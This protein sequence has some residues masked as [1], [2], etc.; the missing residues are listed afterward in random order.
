MNLQEVIKQLNNDLRVSQNLMFN[1]KKEESGEMIKKMMGEIEKALTAD[2]SNAPL[3]VIQAKVLK[4]KTD[5]ERRGVNFGTIGQ[6]NDTKEITPVENTNV[7]L[8]DGITRRINLIQKAIEKKDI[9]TA[10]E[11]WNE[12]VSMYKGQ[13]KDSDAEILEIRGL[14]EKLKIEITET[15]AKQKEEQAEKEYKQQEKQKVERTCMDW[16]MKLN[17][18]PYFG[19]FNTDMSGLKEQYEN[20]NAVS[21]LYAVYQKEDFE[22]SDDLLNKEKEIQQKLLDFPGEYQK[23]LDDIIKVLTDQIANKI[24]YLNSDIKWKSDSEKKIIPNILSTADLAAISDSIKEIE[25]YCKTKTENFENLEKTFTILSDTNAQLR[26]IKVERTYMLSHIYH[27]NDADAIIKAGVDILKKSFND[28]KVLCSKITSN[29]QEK[30]SWQSTDSTNTEAIYKTTRG[31]YI[32]I[33]AKDKS[34]TTFLHTVYLA[35]DKKSDGNWA[36]FY[37]NIVYSDEMLEINAK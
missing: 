7:K 11:N 16:L 8:P 33:A 19:Y 34:N 10:E 25:K 12:I 20:Y 14:I 2:A 23:M 22:K 35:N 15:K 6:Q 17:A 28:I 26:K 37:G 5:L 31:I 32:Q 24:E 4:Q 9:V 29:W 13:Y 30:S 27:A 21:N 18:M 1:G 36:D 3:L